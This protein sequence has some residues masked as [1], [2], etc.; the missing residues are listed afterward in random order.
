MTADKEDMFHF[1]R[2]DYT[3]LSMRPVQKAFFAQ[4]FPIVLL[5]G[6][7]FQVGSFILLHS[8]TIDELAYIGSGVSYIQT[9]RLDIDIFEHPPL[10]KYLIGISLLPV[11]RSFPSFSEA[12]QLGS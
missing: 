12:A 10:M 3:I 9:G 1:R 2:K 7:V 8:N 4:A 11:S 6:L 5:L